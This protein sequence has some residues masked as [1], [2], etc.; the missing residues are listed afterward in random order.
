MKKILGIGNALVDIIFFLENDLLLEAFSLPKG[1]MQLVDADKAQQVEE[2]TAG[3]QKISWLQADLQPI[4]FTDWPDW[5]HGD[6]IYRYRR[7]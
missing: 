2:A 7:K 3:L 4:R 6:C 1:S 5:V